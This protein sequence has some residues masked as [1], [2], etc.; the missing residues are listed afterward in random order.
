MRVTLTQSEAMINEVLKDK[1][2]AYSAC[3]EYY[4]KLELCGATANVISTYNRLNKRS[5]AKKHNLVTVAE[6]ELFDPHEELIAKMIAQF[7]K[8]NEAAALNRLHLDCHVL[9]HEQE[10]QVKTFVL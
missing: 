7:K 1:G 8:E 5:Q 10:Q 9:T 2:E 3:V 6:K 4:N